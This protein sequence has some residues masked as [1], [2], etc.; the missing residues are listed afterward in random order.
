MLYTVMLPAPE[1]TDH[2]PASPHRDAGHEEAGHEEAGHE[3][4]ISQSRTQKKA[5][6]KSP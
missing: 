6:E 3:E 5:R 4:A 2:E 1:S